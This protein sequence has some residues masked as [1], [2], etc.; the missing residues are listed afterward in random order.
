LGG[1]IRDDRV[2]EMREATPEDAGFLSDM[3]LAAC[4][5][6]GEERITRSDIDRNPQLRHYVNDWPREG[7]VGVVA[8]NDDGVPVGAV[9]A[10]RFSV[11]D[12]GYGFVAP[13][14]PELSLAVASAQRGRGI[15]RR[16]L[17]SIVELARQ[18]GW[19]A[20]S[21]SVQDG[22]RATRLY[23]AVGFRAVARNEN[24]QTMLLEIRP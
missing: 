20:V 10:R 19:R 6:S 22:N 14:V 8:V 21:L 4:N 7:D 3:L 12:P 5:W 17:E 13:D 18:R 2:M 23:R 16:L 1:T 9:W 11:D 15:G 24:A